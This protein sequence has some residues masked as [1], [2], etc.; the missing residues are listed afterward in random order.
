MN[1]QD[2]IYTRRKELPLYWYNKSSDLRGAAGAVWTCMDG[3]ISLTVPKELGL[4]ND[5]IMGVAT[6]FL[7][8]SCYAE[9]LLN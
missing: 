3:P 6:H 1:I 9:W 8:I 5:F 2:D 4:G 7:F